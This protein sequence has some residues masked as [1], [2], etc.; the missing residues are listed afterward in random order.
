M[1]ITQSKKKRKTGNV[2]VEET[3]NDSIQLDL[4][5]LTDQVAFAD[6]LQQQQT[7]QN[8]KN[9]LSLPVHV[10]SKF[11]PRGSME[12][13]LK[14]F[15]H[16]ESFEHRFGAVS[17]YNLQNPDLKLLVKSCGANDLRHLIIHADVECENAREPRLQGCGFRW[18]AKHCEQL[19]TLVMPLTFDVKKQLIPR[20]KTSKLRRLTLTNVGSNV[21][22]D[23]LKQL[24]QNS[25]KLSIIEV[26]DKDD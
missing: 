6:F 1:S 19:E 3:K 25:P 18:L 2:V 5:L 7:K 26:D 22:K 15:P 11:F 23:A 12:L 20:L 14:H 16:I 17:K 10:V 8:E 9:S 13:L 4:T 24:I 21:D